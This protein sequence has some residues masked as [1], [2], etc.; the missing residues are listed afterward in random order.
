MQSYFPSYLPKIQIQIQIV[1]SIELR[2]VQIYIKLSEDRDDLIL[3][4]IEIQKNLEKIRNQFIYGVFDRFVIAAIT[5]QVETLIIY[6]RNQYH[7]I[8]FELLTK[9]V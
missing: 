4:G 6:L 2:D 7:N 3:T 8:N 9:E 1:F 5:Q